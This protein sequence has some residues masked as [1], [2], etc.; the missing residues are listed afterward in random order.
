[1]LS[2]AASVLA[3]CAWSF[4]FISILCLSNCI[5]SQDQQPLSVAIQPNRDYPAL[6]GQHHS[7]QKC[8]EHAHK[9][10]TEQVQQLAQQQAQQAQDQAQQQQ[11]QHWEEG[12][13]AGKVSRRPDHTGYSH[14]DSCKYTGGKHQVL[15]GGF[16]DRWEGWGPPVQIYSFS[17]PQK[18]FPVQERIPNRLPERG[19]ISDTKK[20]AK[21]T[22]LTISANAF[23]I[24]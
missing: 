10:A 24:Y 5:L 15:G 17:H 14:C 20:N 8:G 9:L 23:S 16:P 1:L 22:A 18:Q 2:Y 19:H 3:F 4:C 7:E 13:G 11:A 12:K 6:Q 21:T